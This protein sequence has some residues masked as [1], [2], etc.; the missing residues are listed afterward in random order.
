MLGSVFSPYYA[1]A[2]R[3]GIPDPLDYCGLNVALYG[4]RSKR[5][6]LTERNRASLERDA[7]F[8]SLGPSALR[9]DGNALTVDIE[10]VTMPLPTRLRG[11]VRLHPAALANYQAPLDARV[12]HRWSP[13]A[14][15]AWVEVE[16]SR[17]SVRWSGP[18]YFDTNAGDEPLEAAFHGWD[19]SR[20]HH[21]QGTTVLYHVEP[22]GGEG[23]SLAVHF[24]E[25][26]SATP[27]EPPAPA[28][29]PPTPIWRIPRATQA[30]PGQPAIILRTLEDTPFYARTIISSRI[31]GEKVE[32]VHE[33]LSL[34]RFRRPWV[35]ALLPFRMPRVPY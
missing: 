34:D 6:S 19:W 9:W 35:R 10:E 7:G 32:A 30:D 27:F 17:P 5:W 14:P 1:W 24:G 28:P 8:L 18:G 15:R 4:P 11:R 12:R 26:G 20:A 16:M 13:I 22:Q 23:A 25:D 29:L 31:R 21:R 2:R 33:S 3:R